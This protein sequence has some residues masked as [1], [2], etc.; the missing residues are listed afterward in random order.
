MPHRP[1]SRPRRRRSLPDPRGS[2]GPRRPA[3][4]AEADLELDEGVPANARARSERQPEQC[5]P[6]MRNPEPLSEPL[7]GGGD[8][9]TG[10]KTRPAKPVAQC[11]AGLVGGN[12]LNGRPDP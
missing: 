8:P 3:R 4:I 7:C 11:V 12:N 6:A 9:A 5:E 10:G 1:F 2:E